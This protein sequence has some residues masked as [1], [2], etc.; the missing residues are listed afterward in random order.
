MLSAAGV[1]I[2]GLALNKVPLTERS[3]GHYAAQYAVDDQ[4]ATG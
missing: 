1:N 4:R 3:M 2:L